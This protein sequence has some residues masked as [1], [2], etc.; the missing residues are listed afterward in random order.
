MSRPKKSQSS[1]PPRYI[2]EADAMRYTSM[3]DDRLRSLRFSGE[4]P[5]IQKAD[6]CTI[7]YDINDIDAYMKRYKK[8]C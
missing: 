7:F 1:L 6:G 4:L 8:T 2:T 5:Y 3:S